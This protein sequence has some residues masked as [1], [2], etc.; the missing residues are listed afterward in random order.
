MCVGGVTHDMNLR[1]RSRDAFTQQF[2]DFKLHDVQ[3]QIEVRLELSTWTEL[4]G[5]AWTVSVSPSVVEL[6]YSRFNSLPAS[7]VRTN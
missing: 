3:L 6:R 7:S 5:R 1:K 4:L 2:D